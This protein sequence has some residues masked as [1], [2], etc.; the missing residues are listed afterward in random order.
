[1][2]SIFWTLVEVSVRGLLGRR[3]TILLLLLA[4][5]PVL[6]ALLARLA[7]GQLDVEPVFANLVAR[8]V[9]PLT[10]LVFGTAALG[11]ELED[12]TALYVI[13]KPVPRWLVI[14]AKVLVAGALAG[15]LTAGSTILTGFLIA[16]FGTTGLATTFSFA[17]AT[18]LAAFVY[19]A[20]FV[21]LSVMTTRA[22][23]IGLIYTFVWEGILSGVLEGTKLFS[24]REATV[25]L[26]VSLAPATA[27]IVGGLDLLPAIGLLVIVFAGAFVLG[28]RALQAWEA[29]AAD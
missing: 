28:T 23:I 3:R 12:G 9:L 14:A 11:S 10:A 13:A 2:T 21:A 20:I 24:I 29:K 22:L 19:V 26:A 4:G 6:V 18:G 7:G 5:I 25:G 17:V 1:M 27:G 15:A 8:F 16:G